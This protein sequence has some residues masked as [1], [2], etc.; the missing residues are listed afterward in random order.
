M[1]I[2]II[3]GS[4]SQNLRG[5]QKFL[6]Q[7]SKWLS[8]TSIQGIVIC[9]SPKRLARSID[10]NNS[11]MITYE[12]EKP[13][14]IKHF[15]SIIHSWLF[16]FFSFLK[17]IH[18][19]KSYHFSIIQA[20]DTNY[21]AMAALAAAKILHVPVVLLVHGINMDVVRLLIRP[22]W[23]ARLYR[24]YY[25]LLQKESIKR[26]D[27]VI[28]VSENN[29][30]YLP[31]GKKIVIP[32][33]VNTA[34]YHVVQDSADIR[35][36]L[37]IPKHAFTLGYVGALSTGKGLRMLLESFYYMLQEMPQE[38]STYLLIVGDGPEKKE[39]QD[40]AAELNIGQYL[41]LTGFRTDVA[42]LLSIMDVFVFL[43]ESEGSPI[44]ILEAMAAGKAIIASKIPAIREIV[45]NGKEAIL[46][47]PHSMVDLKRAMLLL[48]ND[49]D[50][51]D[52]LARKVRERA[53]LYDI[54]RVYGQMVKLYQE[55]VV[56]K[57]NLRCYGF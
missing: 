9:G 45:R 3:G 33:G 12:D 31:I 29:R 44:A 34:L 22:K 35:E 41:R 6:M 50:L 1:T 27:C 17:V 37:R 40:F 53:E 13:T 32:M 21:C 26:S 16:S 48:F 39:L 14:L 4:T 25:L 2:C 30:E 49:S 46:V 7:F 54:D 55:L 11:S 23:L 47:D 36:E 56:A 57:K 43:S 20:Q 19:N 51:R 10:T 42:R 15:P 5:P 8:N 18:L 38:T 24:A 28:C 52:E